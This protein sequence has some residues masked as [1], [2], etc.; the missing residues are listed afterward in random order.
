[1]IIKN[2]DFLT[3]IQLSHINY[4]RAMILNSNDI[5]KVK[6]IKKE[7]YDIV[8]HAR[9]RYYETNELPDSTKEITSR[10]TIARIEGKREGI[11]EVVRSL[12]NDGMS[13]EKVVEYTPYDEEELSHLLSEQQILES[14]D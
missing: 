10:L 5:T 1:M 2:I 9:K 8:E 7:I 11:L 6:L 4:L 13:F 12:L 14:K 3:N